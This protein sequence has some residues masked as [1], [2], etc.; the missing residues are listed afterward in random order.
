MRKTLDKYLEGAE[1]NYGLFQGRRAVSDDDE[2]VFFRA[3]LFDMSS[4]NYNAEYIA[5][6]T[7]FVKAKEDKNIILKH[8]QLISLRP[9]ST[10][11]SSVIV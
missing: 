7:A 9:T 6:Q 3:L 2:R 1:V 4:E 11:T 5:L 10:L 8:Y